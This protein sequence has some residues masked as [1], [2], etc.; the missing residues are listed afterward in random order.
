M[1]AILFSLCNTWFLLIIWVMKILLKYFLGTKAP[2]L[3][4]L[5]TTQICHVECIPVVYMEDDQSV[6]IFDYISLIKWLI[7]FISIFVCIKFINI[8]QRCTAL[9]SLF[10]NPWLLGDL[11]DRIVDERNGESNAM[12]KILSS[13]L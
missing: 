7:L 9:T 1:L 4:L 5:D 10:P 13:W 2:V 6:G 3:L 12:Y 11:F 8:K